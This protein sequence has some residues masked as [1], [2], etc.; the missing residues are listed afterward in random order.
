[1]EDRLALVAEARRAV[2]HHALALRGANRG[3]EVGLL[4]QAA[5]ALAAFGRVKRDHVIARFHRRYARADLAHDA[6]ALVAEDRGKDSLAVEAVKRIGV[7][8]TDPRRLYLDED[9]TGLRPV[10]IDLDDLKRLLGFERDGGA[11]L[12]SQLHFRFSSRCKNIL[13]HQSFALPKDHFLAHAGI[14]RLGVG[15]RLVFLLGGTHA[16]DGVIGAGTQIDVDVVHVAGDVRVIAERRHHI[17][18]RRIHVLAAA[19]DHAEEV[20]IT[21]GLD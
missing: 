10:Q 1:M 9:F 18:L 11:C 14:L 13:V 16:P 6:G 7:G 17:F 19:G 21:H 12:H 20:A 5:F 8:V 2:G 15:L 4:A 3:A